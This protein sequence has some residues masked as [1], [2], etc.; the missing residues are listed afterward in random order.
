M[1]RKIAFASA[2]ALFATVQAA[3]A[4][5]LPPQQGGPYKWFSCEVLNT[6]IVPHSVTIKVT[7]VNTGVVKGQK[8]VTI[9]PA[10][11]KGVGGYAEDILFCEVTGI[12]KKLSRT[13]F[14]LQ[15]NL[16]HC[17]S[18]VTAP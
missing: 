13:T 5:I 7:Q 18:V 16:G 10:S 2:F 15:T 11:F 1:I 8:T 9:Q 14:C 12:E 4:F 17:V 3:S 6:D